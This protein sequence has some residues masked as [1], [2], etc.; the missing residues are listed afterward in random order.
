[1]GRTLHIRKRIYD[2]HDEGSINSHVCACST[3]FISSGRDSHTRLALFL[4]DRPFLEVKKRLGWK[5]R[6]E[7]CCWRY[8][9]TYESERNA[10]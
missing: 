6:L 8:I 7:E 4:L 9:N 1:M 10:P 2:I 5:L 3:Q